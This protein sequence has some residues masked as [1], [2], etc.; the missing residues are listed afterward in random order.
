MYLPRDAQYSC[1]PSSTNAQPVLE[2]QQTPW[3]TA[4]DFSFFIH[5]G[6]ESPFAQFRPAVLVLSRPSSLG[7]L[8]YSHWQEQEAETFLAL[9]PL[10]SNS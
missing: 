4:L 7:P 6:M 5:D 8:S 2:Q 10:L 1:S 3:P 9:H